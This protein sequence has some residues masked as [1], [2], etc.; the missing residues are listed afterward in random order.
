MN[1][2]KTGKRGWAHFWNAFIFLFFLILLLAASSVMFSPK[3]N[4]KQSGT[5]YPESEGYLSEPKN[6]IDLFVIGNS[7]AY[8]GFSPMELWN[9]RGYT[10]Y[11]SAIPRQ[12]TVEAVQMLQ[13]IFTNQT[14]RVVVLDIDSVYTGNNQFKHTIKYVFSTILPVFT[15]HNRWK[16]VQPSEF[17]EL[18]HYTYHS[19]SKGQELNCA[20]KACTKEEYMVPTEKKEKIPL[21]ALYGLEQ[22]RNICKE[23]GI[24][25]LLI[26][27]PSADSWNYSRHNAIQAYANEHQLPFLDLNLNREAFSFDWKTDTTDGGN[28]LNRQGAQKVTQ[29]LSNY[30][31]GHYALTDHRQDVAFNSW[32]SDYEE[33]LQDK[34]NLVERGQ[35]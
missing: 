26:E 16:T 21:L 8:C 25:L 17:F 7:D 33:Y 35:N 6:T 30:F 2:T 19:F 27:M 11:V 4:T 14:P 9:Q 32:N 3:D 13:E 1:Q 23:R 28:H 34:T 5:Y 18:P 31:A 20:V 29:Y 22:F 15:F 10:S 24:E 12:R